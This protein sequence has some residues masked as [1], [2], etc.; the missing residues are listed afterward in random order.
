M[1]KTVCTKTLVVLALVA[2]LCSCT[3]LGKVT[4]PAPATVPGG[5]VGKSPAEQAVDANAPFLGPWGVL[6]TALAP[7]VI[8]LV[9]SVV[10]KKSTAAVLN[11]HA[12]LI[13]SVTPNTDAVPYAATLGT[14]PGGPTGAAGPA[15]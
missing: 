11:Q 15:N 2:T 7:G 6:A 10:T 13:D 4:E 5:Q 8:A 14:P 3:W 12:G 9:H 1:K